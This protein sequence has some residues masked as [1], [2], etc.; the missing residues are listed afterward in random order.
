M[1]ALHV[2]PCNFF[3]IFDHFEEQWRTLLSHFVIVYNIV[4]KDIHALFCNQNRFG[5]DYSGSSNMEELQMILEEC[6]MIR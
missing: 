6:I 4:T 5:W 1:E 3:L 2:S